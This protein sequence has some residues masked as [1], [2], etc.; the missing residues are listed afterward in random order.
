MGIKS[1]ARFCVSGFLAIVVFV[2][3]VNVLPPVR[4]IFNFIGSVGNGT[5]YVVMT[6]LVFVLGGLVIPS[7]TYGDDWGWLS[8]KSANNEEE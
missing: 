2:I 1:L 7:S 3:C 8:D 4:G 5:G 6:T